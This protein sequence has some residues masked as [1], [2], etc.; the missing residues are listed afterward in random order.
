M[1]AEQA[2]AFVREHGAVLVSA[3]GPLPKLTEAIAGQAIKGSWWGHPKGHEIF[4]V[5]NAVCDSDDILVC[6][7]VDA[8]LTLVHS[9]LWPALVAA[10][11]NFQPEQLCRVRQEHSASGK[12]VNQETPFPQWVPADIVAAAKAIPLEQALATL[13]PWSSH[14]RAGKRRKGAATS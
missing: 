2:L 5:L 10:A 8:R 7:L 14:G 3:A 6:R 13:G 4:A 1:N 11:A 12:H 9:R